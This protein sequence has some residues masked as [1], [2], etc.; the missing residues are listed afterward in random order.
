MSLIEWSDTFST[1]IQYLD[2]EHERLIE[3]LNTLC[4]DVCRQG[5]EPKVTDGFEAL[6]RMV[7]AHFSLEEKLMRDHGFD[8]YEDHKAEHERLLH[9]INALRARHSDGDFDSVEDLLAARLKTWFLDHF[10]SAHARLET[11]RP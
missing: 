9:E 4:D 1:G 2:H 11:L 7:A 3:V 5:A 6:Y 10:R 8:G